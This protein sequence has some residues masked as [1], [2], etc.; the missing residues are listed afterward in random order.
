MN[1]I[2][3]EVARM[4]LNKMMEGNHFSIC[5]VDNILQITKGVPQK[6]DYDT[7][8]L[9]HCVDFRDFTPVMREEFPKLLQRV[10][11][12][13]TMQLEIGFKKP[14]NPIEVITTRLLG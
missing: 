10:L 1:A 7:L 3:L 5:T 2:Q 11:E 8:R 12:S 4:A 6:E 14:V 9:L 13:P